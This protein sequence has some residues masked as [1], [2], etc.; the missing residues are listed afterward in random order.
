MLLIWSKAYVFAKLNNLEMHTSSWSRIHYGAWLRMERK[1]RLY[2]GYFKKGGLLKSIRFIYYLNTKKKVIEP[3]VQQINEPRMD[4][5]FVFN[6]IFTEYDFF[7]D[8]RPYKELI[9]NAI[10]EMLEPRLI[11]QYNDYKKPVIGLHI[12]RGD[13]TIGSTITPL[14]FFVEVVN[15]LRKDAGSDLPVTV[16]TD[17]EPFEIEE[18]TRLKN[19]ALAEPKPDIL[20]ML[21]LASSEIVVLSIG[22]TF[23]YWAAFLSDNSVIKNKVEWHLPFRA[24][25]DKNYFKEVVWKKDLKF[26]IDNQRQY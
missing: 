1:K 12:R 15:G 6:K 22:S 8:I 4:T 7:K 19:I 11:E 5:I 20:D 23:S 2:F 14:S 17:A 10:F 21:L 18:L 16:F 25:S 26:K 24:V 9:K 3:A 13:F